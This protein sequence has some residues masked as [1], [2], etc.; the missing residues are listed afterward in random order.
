MAC[1]HQPLGIQ[2]T[3]EIL[4]IDSSDCPPHVSTSP[5][6]NIIS[7]T[8]DYR[9]SIFQQPHPHTNSNQTNLKP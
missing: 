2:N 6:G 9:L 5:E 7:N 1:Q 3:W 8:M 4:I